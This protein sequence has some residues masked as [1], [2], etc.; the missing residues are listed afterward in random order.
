MP[1]TLAKASP[2]I[3]APQVGV[4]KLTKPLAATN[5]I[6]V[7]SGLYPKLTDNGTTIGVDNVASPDDDGTS[8][9]NNICNIIL[10]D[11]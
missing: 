5:V 6:I 7:T 11:L 4:I 1:F 2:P 10:L 8:I 9:D 3:I